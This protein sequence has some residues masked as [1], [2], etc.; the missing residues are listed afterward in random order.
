MVNGKP[1]EYD[2][3]PVNYMVD[4]MKLYFECGILPGSFGTALL[5]NDGSYILEK[6]TPR[7]RFDP[8]GV[9]WA[10]EAESSHEP[11]RTNSSSHNRS[12]GERHVWHHAS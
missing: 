6:S 10:L 5:E 12:G 11:N 2:R 9:T 7:A 8:A 3:I 4:G 1:I